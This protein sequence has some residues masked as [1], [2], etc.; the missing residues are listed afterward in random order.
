MC[1]SELT[2]RIRQGAQIC[3]FVLIGRTRREKA[4]MR[5]CN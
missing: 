5:F 4:D 2:E 1:V 3:V